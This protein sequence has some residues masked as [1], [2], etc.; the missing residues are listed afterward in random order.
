MNGGADSDTVNV[1]SDAPSIP[2]VPTNQVGTIDS[3]NG[4]LTVNGGTGTGIDVLNV[5]DSD[6]AVTGKSG[7][8]TAST[9]RGLALEQGI[10][11]SQLETLN[12]WLATGNNTFNIT[13]THGGSTTS[14]RPRA[15]TPST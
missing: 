9:L 3:I 4:L 7:T 1:G 13:S 12:I 15:R 2:T 8:L 14:T 11:Y 6:P 10:D 5:D